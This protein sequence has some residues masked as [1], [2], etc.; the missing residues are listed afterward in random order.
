MF[1]AS[2]AASSAGGF[3]NA[4]SSKFGSTGGLVVA[5]GTNARSLNWHDPDGGCIVWVTQMYTRFDW[6]PRRKPETQ[7][8]RL[9]TSTSTLL[10]GTTASV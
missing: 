3:F 2:G 7:A 10:L 1:Q 5:D 4:M 8:P 9:L 6:M